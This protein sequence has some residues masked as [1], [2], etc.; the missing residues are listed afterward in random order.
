MQAREKYVSIK[1]AEFFKEIDTEERA[2]QWV[3]LARFG[4]QEFK[5]RHCADTQYY[6]HKADPEIRTCKSCTKQ[7]RLRAGTIFQDSKTPILTWVRAIYF[8][9]QSKRGISALELKRLLGM[10]SYGTT[11]SILHKIRRALRDRDERYKIKDII[12]LDG[13]DFAKVLGVTGETENQ[14]KHFIDL[15]VEKRAVVY[16][17]ANRGFINLKKS[18]KVDVDIRPRVTSYDKAEAQRWLPWVHR[19]ISNAKAFL[20]RTHHGVEAKYLEQYLSEYTYRF[21]RRHDP[22]SLFHRALT[23][24]AIARPVPAHVLFG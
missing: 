19:F 17:D 3:W 10:R 16:T 4:G 22:D 15:A 8:V 5:C 14:T 24:C 18:A 20:V 9:T 6:Q 11:W 23:S 21:N 13:A 2:R 7:N 1:I 12:E